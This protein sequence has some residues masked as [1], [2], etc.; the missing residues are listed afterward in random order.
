MLINLLQQG[1]ASP[2]FRSMFK[3]KGKS[4]KQVKQFTVP[5]RGVPTE[6]VRVFIRFLYSS[7]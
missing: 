3:R 2:V 1:L 5:I 6:A 4:K 7:W